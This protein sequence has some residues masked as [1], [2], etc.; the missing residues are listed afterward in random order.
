M[1]DFVKVPIQ[2]VADGLIPL[3]AYFGIPVAKLGDDFVSSL[4]P[5]ICEHQDDAL[6]VDIRYRKGTPRCRVVEREGHFLTRPSHEHNA[7]R[8]CVKKNS[9]RLGLRVV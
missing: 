9:G 4:F 8:R 2:C 1:C 5:R 7:T 6:V 3:L